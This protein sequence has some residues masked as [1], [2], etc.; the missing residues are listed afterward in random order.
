MWL[1][2]IGYRF[3]AGLPNV[4]SASEKYSSSLTLGRAPL[5]RRSY[6]KETP[7]VSWSRQEDRTQNLNLPLPWVA[8]SGR[9][10][11]ASLW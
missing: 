3:E 1:M 4:R 5:E 9:A 11:A 8:C 7:T 2:S 10:A 6:E